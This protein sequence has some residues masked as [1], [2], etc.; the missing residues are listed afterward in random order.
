MVLRGLSAIGNARRARAGA[1]VL[2]L[3]L[4]HVLLAPAGSIAVRIAQHPIPKLTPEEVVSPAS[5]IFNG[6]QGLLIA[7]ARK[8]AYQTVTTAPAFAVSAGAGGAPAFSFFLGPD[9]TTWL[10]SRLSEAGSATHEATSY[11]TLDELTPGSS[12][13][14]FKYPTPGSAP[15]SA[16]TGPDGA[17]WL[18]ETTDSAVD[19]IAAGALT[20]FPMPLAD[21]APLRIVSGPGG[22]LWT[23]NLV[24]G[25]I[26]QIAPSGAITE[27][28][29]PGPG[30]G[31]FGNAEPLRAGRGTGRSR[32]VR[33]AERSSDRTDH[34]RRR[35][36]D[37]SRSRPEAEPSP[38]PS[39]TPSHVTSR[40]DRKAASGSRTRERTRSAAYRV[41]ASA[42]SRSEAI[43]WYPTP[44]WRP[45]VEL[46]FNEENAP[47]LGS[48][49][50]VAAPSEETIGSTARVTSGDLARML[51]VPRKRAHTSDLLR[52]GGYTATTSLPAAGVITISWSTRKHVTVAA[53]RETLPAAG[54]GKLQIRLTAAGRKLL[55]KT[56]ALELTARGR[57][58]LDGGS[59][60]SAVKSLTIKPGSAR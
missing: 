47:A 24:D 43:G 59:P 46:W 21:A 49:D 44:S 31:A 55:R 33:R 53:G 2:A 22:D 41:A 26:A 6:P 7:G 50:P 54:A 56:K 60:V 42:S 20:A 58:T 9:G 10:I 8:S 17:V 18:P 38:A 34:R 36:R 29:L 4:L 28:R 39:A 11:T 19:R 13:L 57:A 52:H 35:N 37:R 32:V 1:A 12:T 16:V 30:V 23:T 15:L 51:S 3:S 48:V 14:R 5:T 40:W 25:A 27:H 45:V